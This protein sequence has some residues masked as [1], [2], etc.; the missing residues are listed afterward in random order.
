MH[1]LER[2]YDGIIIGAGHHGLVLG[3]YLAKAGLDILIVER[4]LDYGGGLCTKEVT[5]PG[6]Y[7]NLHSINHFHISETPWFKDLSLGERVTYITPRYEF[8]QAHHDGTALVPRP[9]PSAP[10]PELIPILQIA[11]FTNVEASC[12]RVV[13]PPRARGRCVA[14]ARSTCILIASGSVSAAA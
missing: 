3:A 8:G 13:C 4:R 14:Y 7:H 12:K 9:E 5:E 1:A 6:F 10:I 2:N 11:I